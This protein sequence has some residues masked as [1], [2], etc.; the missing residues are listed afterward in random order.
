MPLLEFRCSTCVKDFE[1][2]VRRDESPVCPICQSV[3]VEKLISSPTARISG[4][5]PVA[6]ACPPIEA[7][8]CKPGCCR[9][10]Q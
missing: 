4:S 2:L 10:P 7:G 1:V 3:N 9:L 8:P 6:G 5:L